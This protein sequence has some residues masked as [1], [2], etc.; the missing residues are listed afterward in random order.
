MAPLTPA[1]WSLLVSGSG[2]IIDQFAAL[3]AAFVAGLHSSVGLAVGARFLEALVRRLRD[4]LAGGVSPDGG[5]EGKN[6][7]KLLA[8]LYVFKVCDASLIMEFV[9]VLMEEFGDD[10]VPI[11]LATL[12]ACGPS[13]KS[14]DSTAFTKLIA[15]IKD[16]A[17]AKEGG[18]AERTSFL[19]DFIYELQGRKSKKGLGSSGDA[20]AEVKRLLKHLKTRQ[21]KLGNK[22]QAT[23]LRAKWDDLARGKLYG[24]WWEQG[25]RLTRVNMA[26]NSEV[27][28][29]NEVEGDAGEEAKRLRDLASKQHMGSG[30]RKDIFT[31]MMSSEDYMDAFEKLIRLNL[32]DL[33]VRYTLNPKTPNTKSSNLG[34]RTPCA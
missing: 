34:H 29:G 8:H 16:R 12:K 5:Q 28:T 17:A 11:L 13:L 33:Q 22:G 19:L 2:A 32:K 26:T 4:I 30:V 31:V 3:Y 14:E 9:D 27:I 25:A 1:P 18:T 21:S 6:L 15:S 20:D 10:E 23:V 7:A 24:P